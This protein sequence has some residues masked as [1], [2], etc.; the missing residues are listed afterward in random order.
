MNQ[1]DELGFEVSQAPQKRRKTTV[2]FD[3][4]QHV[5][6]RHKLRWAYMQSIVPVSVL[7]DTNVFVL[8]AAIDGVYSVPPAERAS[9]DEFAD[10]VGSLPGLVISRFGRN[11]YFVHRLR[12]K[13]KQLAAQAAYS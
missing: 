8:K 10:Y 5:Q 11:N 2:E 1:P 12:A 3:L 6:G 4:T 7:N 9:L 13:K